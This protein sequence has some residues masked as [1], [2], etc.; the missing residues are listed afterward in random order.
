[1]PAILT[2]DQFG[3]DALGAATTVLGF[4]TF[5]EHDAFL[6]GN[7]GPDPLFY[8]VADPGIDKATHG[9]GELMH[10]AK[11][12]RLLMSLHDSI[13]ML[14]PEERRIG[15]AY[16]A[17]FLCHYLLDSSAHPLIFS[18]QYALCDAGVE[19]LDRTDGS[20]VH[21]EIEKDLDEAVLYKHTGETIAE[22]L[23]WKKCLIASDDT[24]AIVDKMYFYMGLWTY[25]LTLPLDIFTHAVKSFRK[26]QHLFWAPHPLKRRAMGAV[27]SVFSFNRYSLYQAMAHSPRAE[28]T[29]VFDNREHRAWQD[30][31][32]GRV[33]T[34]SFWDLYDGAL[35]CA[36]VTSEMLFDM[37][38]NQDVAQALTG[39]RNFNGEVVEH[40]LASRA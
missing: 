5:D 37:K 4:S 21:A 29:S 40:G 6:L 12:N 23:P 14:P 33:R 16:A 30:P 25:N 9:V 38:F 19:S 35:A 24:L 39:G 3:H 15:E 28:E 11:T 18:Q 32:T 27:E 1:M 17:G 20:R 7:Q 22:F 13:E 26:I 2:H 34:E 36:L 10:H 31:F 8:L